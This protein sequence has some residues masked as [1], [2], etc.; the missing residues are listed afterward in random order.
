[1]NNDPTISFKNSTANTDK[2]LYFHKILLIG[3]I[4]DLL[5]NL[6]AVLRPYITLLGGLAIGF[7]FHYIYKS[8]F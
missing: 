5:N 1:M 4:S 2:Q 8:T 7:K 6:N 3:A